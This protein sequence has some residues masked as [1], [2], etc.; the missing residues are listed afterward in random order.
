MNAALGTAGVTLGL[1]AC[2]AGAVTMVV[3]LRG[4]RA[5]LIRD[6]INELKKQSGQAQLTMPAKR[7][8][9]TYGAKGKRGK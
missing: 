4:E 9:V 2:V 1:I 6:Q 7:K 8:K 3:G 5:A